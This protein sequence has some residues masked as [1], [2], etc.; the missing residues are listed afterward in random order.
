MC[1]GSIQGSDEFVTVCPL[2]GGYRLLAIAV[3]TT[4][5]DCPPH[6]PGRALISASGS[7]R[8]WITAKRTAR[9]HTRPPVGHAQTRSVSGTCQMEERSPRSAAFPPHSPPTMLRLCS[10]DSSVLYRGVTPRRRARGPCGLSP[11]PPS[12]GSVAATGVSEVSRFSCMKFLDVPWGL[13]PRRTDR[14]LALTFPSVLPSAHINRVGVWVVCF[15]GSMSPPAYP[16]STLRCFPHGSSAR[17]EAKWIAT[18]FL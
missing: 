13:R 4:I 15:R 11:L 9:P 5:A 14:E 10:N 3:G 6:G 17:L 2:F 1:W 12:C 8:G 7:Y 16:L 18:P